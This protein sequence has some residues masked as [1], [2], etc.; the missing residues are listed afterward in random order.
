MVWAAREKRLPTR[1]EAWEILGGADAPP[2]GWV[3]E[4]RVVETVRSLLD[5]DRYGYSGRL[6]R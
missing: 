1:N 3:A 5:A 4:E 6:A 2:F